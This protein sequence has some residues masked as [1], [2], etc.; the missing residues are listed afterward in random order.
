MK[1]VM[2]HIPKA[3]G[4]SLKNAI[5]DKVGIDNIYFDYNRPLAK[6]DFHRKAQ[7][8]VASIVGRPRNETLIFGHFLAGKYA[9]FNGYYFSR[10]KG[11]AYAIFLR[12]PL[13][14]AI[15]HFFFWKRTAVTGHQVWERFTRE[16]WSLEQFLLSRE[17]TN[18]QAKFLWRFPL[19]QFDFVGLTEHFNDSVKMLGCVFP[20]LK[21]LPIKV[22]NRN[23]QNEIGENYKIDSCLVYEFMRRNKLDYA[24]YNQATKLFLAQKNTLLK[25]GAWE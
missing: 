15:S 17:H 22:E 21:D 3:A 16:N 25:A 13:Q 11:V 19:S 4:T 8:L 18:F 12:D 14:R 5:L 23:P 1:I 20:L 7:C 6:D 24:L 2:V 10:C 9:R